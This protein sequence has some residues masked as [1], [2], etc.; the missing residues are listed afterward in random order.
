MEW[1]VAGPWA[2]LAE[3]QPV[4]WSSD[5]GRRNVAQAACSC[6]KDRTGQGTAKD[7]PDWPG[8]FPCM[9]EYI[10]PKRILAC[11]PGRVL[12]REQ[13]EKIGIAN[14]PSPRHFGDW[15]GNIAEVQGA[16]QTTSLQ[17]QL[18]PTFQCPAAQALR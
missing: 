10:W 12:G 18:A 17:T 1:T 6:D 11:M 3:R 16:V 8:D 4:A 14:P 2:K 5:S 13:G 15:E 7:I 9:S